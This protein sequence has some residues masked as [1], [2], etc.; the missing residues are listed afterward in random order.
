[1]A[2]LTADR[3]TKIIAKPSL[4]GYPVA[5][6]TTIYKGGMVCLDGDGYAVPAAD[7]SAYSMVIGVADEQVDNSSGSDGDKDVRVRSGEIYDFVASSITQAMVGTT[8]YV[9]DDQTI[10]DS[11]GVTHD[12]IAGVLVEYVS[13]TNGKVH[14]PTPGHT[15]SAS[16]GTAE[17]EAKAATKAKLGD[18]VLEYSQLVF[19]GSVDNQTVKLGPVP[20]DCEITTISYFTAAALGS[21]VG[22]DV[23][24]GGTD[25][26]GS[27]VVDSSD[28]N[29]DGQ[30]VNES[31]GHALTAGDH[32]NI[33]FDDFDAATLCVVTVTLKHKVNDT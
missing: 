13:A 1:M 2:A 15:P 5:A 10:D 18:D 11:A 29:L 24:D 7:D 26:T 16:V 6:S 28:D 14:I 3:D 19:A 12:V 32:I 4:K 27:A 31:V 22:I 9:V 17:L 25:G 8:M 20:V 23:V 33:T 30:D 21:G